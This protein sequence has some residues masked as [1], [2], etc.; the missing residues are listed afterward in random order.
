MNDLLTNNE[1]SSDYGKLVN[2]EMIEIETELN[3]KSRCSNKRNFS[4]PELDGPVSKQGKRCDYASSL[5]DPS[6]NFPPRLLVF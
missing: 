4:Y 6:H 1:I 3:V 5:I 2:D